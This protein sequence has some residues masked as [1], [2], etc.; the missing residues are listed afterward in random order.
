MEDF[1]YNNGLIN[2]LTKKENQQ[3]FKKSSKT[4]TQTPKTGAT[5]VPLIG[6]SYMYIETGG[7]SFGSKIFVSFEKTGILRISNN[8]FF[9]D[10]YSAYGNN[11]E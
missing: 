8:I 2:F 7:S 5:V 4:N 6:D 10:R 3:S 1:S 9:Y 11:K